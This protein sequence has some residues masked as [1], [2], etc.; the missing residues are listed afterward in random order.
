M[1]EE[2][3]RKRIAKEKPKV[4]YIARRTSLRELTLPIKLERDLL[5]LIP[6]WEQE[7][8]QPFLV[9]GSRFVEDLSARLEADSGGRGVPRVSIN[10]NL[11]QLCQLLTT[12]GSHVLQVE[13]EQLHL[14]P[15]S[16]LS[17]LEEPLRR[18]DKPELL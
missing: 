15:R 9:H 1:R 8:N 16:K 6:Q 17:L 7:W 5:S 4:G 11:R 3:L 18:S 13:P 2:K 10:A 14:L 12:L